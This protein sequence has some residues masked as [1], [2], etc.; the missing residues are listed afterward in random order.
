[1]GKKKIEKPEETPVESVAAEVIVNPPAPAAEAPVEIP[2][3]GKNEVVVMF[4]D[5]RGIEVPRTFSKDV[6]GKDFMKLAQEFCDT[7]ARA[8]AHIME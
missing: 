6:H 3:A 1:M 2:K 5:H 8:G 7:N 4:R